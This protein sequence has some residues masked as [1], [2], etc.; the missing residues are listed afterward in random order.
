[1]NL[2]TGLSDI[3][4]LK[5]SVYADDSTMTVCEMGSA[6]EA[7]SRIAC[8]VYIKVEARERLTDSNTRNTKTQYKEIKINKCKSTSVLKIKRIDITL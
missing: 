7:R 3:P 5:G 2:S 1:M 4:Y 6:G 8:G